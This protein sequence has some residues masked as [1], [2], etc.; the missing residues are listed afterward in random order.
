MDRVIN[1]H[2]KFLYH[3]WD[4]QHI[5]FEKSTDCGKPVIVKFAGHLNR[6]KGPD[7][8]NAVLSIDGVEIQ[9]DVEIHIN[10][11]DWIAHN[12]HDDPNYNHVVLHVVYDNKSEQAFTIKENG[13]LIPILQLKDILSQDIN[14]LFQEAS[15]ETFVEQEKYCHLFS[16]QNEWVPQILTEYGKERFERKVKR[17]KAELS[18]CSFDQLIYQGLLESLGY[19]NNK[20]PFYQLA[21]QVPYIKIQQLIMNGLSK[22]DILSLLLHSSDLINHM[23]SQVRVLLENDLNDSFVKNDYELISADYDWN[24]FRL[25]P[26]NHPVLRLIQVLDFIYDSAEIGLTNHVLKLFSFEKEKLSVSAF[27]KRSQLVLAKQTIKDLNT[28]IG[29]SRIDSILINIFIPIIYIYAQKMDFIDLQN[30][31]YSLFIDFP[32]LRENT[33]S[34]TMRKYLTDEI[35][36]NI[37]QKAINQQG[38]IQVYQSYCENHLCEPCRIK[39]EEIKQR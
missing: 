3:I 12:H 24:M 5:L 22:I 11:Y 18:F 16:V 28:R 39:L 19:S 37:Q 32:G 30:Y 14:K 21:K 33:I 27:R 31:T 23:P 26:V 13:E 38:L 4:Q 6:G 15:D 8:K 1:F 29:S 25:M 10:S 36:N 20:F 34:N 35:E 2:E 9:G 7:F 17:F